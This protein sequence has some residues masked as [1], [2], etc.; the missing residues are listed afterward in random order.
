MKNFALGYNRIIILEEGWYQINC[1]IRFQ[2]GGAERWVYVL[3]N[4][5]NT[6]T[7]SIDSDDANA[8]RASTNL[9]DTVYFKKGDAINISTNSVTTKPMAS[10]RISM[11]KIEGIRSR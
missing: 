5:G 4:S 10:N 7:M 8:D 2:S 11:R 6:I 3:D 9:I 1:D